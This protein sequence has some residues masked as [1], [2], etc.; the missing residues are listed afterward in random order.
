MDELSRNIDGLEEENKEL[1][2]KIEEAN[3]LNEK[4]KEMLKNMTE[5]EKNKAELENYLARKEQ[6]VR[7]LNDLVEKVKPILSET[8]LE[9]SKSKFNDDPKKRED[10][11]LNMNINDRTIEEYLSDL[12]KYI[13]TLMVIRHENKAKGVHNVKEMS[14]NYSKPLPV[15][16]YEELNKDK[17]DGRE[18]NRFIDETKFREYA[19]EYW[20]KRKNKGK[21]I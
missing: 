2:R 3:K 5:E 8:L 16:S 12:E 21:E 1:E 13:N 20:E 19:N 10:Y 11:E 17:L 7:D 18:E 9:L 15:I 6:S 14:T 4:K